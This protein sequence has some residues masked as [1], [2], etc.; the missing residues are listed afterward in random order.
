LIYSILIFLLGFALQAQ[1][2]HSVHLAIGGNFS[3][4]DQ[5]DINT[6]ASESSTDVSFD[7]NYLVKVKPKLTLSLGLAFDRKAFT[8][9]S[10][11]AQEPTF[12]LYTLDYIAPQVGLLYFPTGELVYLSFRGKYGLLQSAAIQSDGKTTDLGKGSGLISQK[13]F[14]I[15]PG[16]GI[17]FLLNQK[18]TI[19]IGIQAGYDISLNNHLLSDSERFSNLRVGLSFTYTFWKGKKPK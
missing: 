9:K 4:I 16:L 8:T 6:T 1:V 10:T 11:S 15:Q 3:S 5:E 13:D 2:S 7:F 14:I 19:G 12:S 18:E 17:T